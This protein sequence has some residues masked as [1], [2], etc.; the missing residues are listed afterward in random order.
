MTKFY[1]LIISRLFNNKSRV[2]KPDLCSGSIS[3]FN[4]LK[5]ECENQIMEIG[6]K[7]YM[8]RFIIWKVV[9]TQ[10]KLPSQFSGILLL[11]EHRT[12]TWAPNQFLLLL[13]IQPKHEHINYEGK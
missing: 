5:A 10:T 2:R 13:K 4:F 6:N 7:S 9:I 12:L 1:L 11:P 8:T 3:N